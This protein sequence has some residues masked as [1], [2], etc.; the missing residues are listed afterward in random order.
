MKQT[1]K[2]QTDYLIIGA[3]ISGL[4][5]ANYLSE[6]GSVTLITKGK[7]KAAYRYLHQ[8]GLAAALSSED[9]F[10]SHFQ[11]TLS[12]GAGL[13]KDSSVRQVIFGA[14]KVFKH[15]ESLGLKF[16]KKPLL[17]SGHSHPRTWITSETTG[18]DIFNLFLKLVQK[19]K[20]ISILESTEAVELFLDNEICKGVYIRS[21]KNE[22]ANIEF[23]GAKKIILATGGLGQLFLHTSNS[24]GAAGGG[25][26]LAVN[27][28]LELSH[29][30]FVQFHPTAL[31]LTDE[32]FH[33]LLPESLRGMGAKIVDQNGQAF[34]SRFDERGDLAQKDLVARAVHIER[35]HGPVYLDMRM[36]NFTELK[37]NY[38]D[39]LQ[40]LKEYKLDPQLDL[41]PIR[42]VAD[43]SCGG[44]PVDLKGST[45]LKGLYAL[46]EVANTGL[47]GAN[48]LSSNP[49]LE[50]L[51]YARVIFE[52][53]K[54]CAD[55]KF[56][57][58]EEIPLPSVAIEN[59][60]QIKAYASRIAKIMSENV[61][62]IRTKES[63]LRAKRE[64]VSIPARDYRVQYRQL[65]CYKMIEAAQKR[66]A[67]IGSHYIGNEID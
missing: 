31:A 53:L 6:I 67:S 43:F 59:L 16:K 2:K 54:E 7:L 17:E 8:S 37:N 27:A 10:E 63:L 20:S 61:G 19:N 24:A 11:D 9:D 22:D 3:G 44:I 30:E 4:V 60:K 48:A 41:I 56:E 57:L 33:Y 52:A 51:V 14:H 40:C 26:A 28:G 21:V 32:S 65:V 29:L 5:L 18:S 62:L 64:I 47:H 49:L 46:G 23:I 12:S 13:C 25:L 45:Q 15:L 36:L 38:S 35:H 1:I 39:L 58:P 66:H 42:A 34:L 55:D 50:G